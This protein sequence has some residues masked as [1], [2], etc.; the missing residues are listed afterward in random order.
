[1]IF[2][3]ILVTVLTG[4]VMFLLGVSVGV[5]IYEDLDSN[6]EIT[7]VIKETKRFFRHG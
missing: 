3:M 5:E 6:F 4:C 7:D 2:L 1:M